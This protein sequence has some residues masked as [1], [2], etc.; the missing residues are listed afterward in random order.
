MRYISGLRFLFP[1]FVAL[2]IFLFIEVIEF[3]SPFGGYG[4]YVDYYLMMF[5]YFFGGVV[6]L[7]PLS[8]L[9]Y[10][11]SLSSK[12]LLWS[13]QMANLFCFM[14][15]LG[16]FMVIYDR[17]FI[18]GVD[19]SQGVS[20]AREDWR[21]VS[22]ART[23]VSSPLSVLGNI[24]Y[25]LVFISVIIN[26]VFYETIGRSFLRLVFCF[27]IVIC[28]SLVIGGRTSVLILMCVALGACVLRF[29]LGKS[30]LP[31]K[32]LGVAS[33]A[34]ISCLAFS[35]LIFYWRMAGSTVDFSQYAS[36][37]VERHGGYIKVGESVG[38]STVFEALLYSVVVY[39]VHVKWVFQ[40]ILTDNAV[41]QG[42]AFLN[43]VFWILSSRGGFDLSIFSYDLDWTHSG[44]WISLPGATWHD[45]G[46]VGVLLISMFL[47]SLMFAMGSALLF[48]SRFGG[49]FQVLFLVIYSAFLTVFVMSPFVF[50]L[51]VVE[52]VYMVL[53]VFIVVFLL[54]FYNFIS[55]GVGR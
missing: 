46:S 23:G 8:L 52:F 20:A 37:L 48:F 24:L 39:V 14:A 4:S 41:L 35:G 6:V 50:L 36:S 44:K 51:D 49:R 11:I 38:D 2:V 17:V 18:Q 26:F 7:L 45:F 16:V 19:Y 31:A 29:Q 30:F 43:Q 22:T 28:F 5:L 1:L 10:E 27:L 12:A 40:S 34:L 32:F 55:L 15:L 42:N 13:G 21:A 53:D 33:L 9:R 54:G 25:P 47:F 3:F